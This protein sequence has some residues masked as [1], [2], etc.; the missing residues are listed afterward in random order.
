IVTTFLVLLLA[1]RFVVWAAQRGRSVSNPG[2]RL[3][4]GNLHRPGNATTSVMLSVGLGLTVLATIAM[5]ERNLT[6]QIEQQLP[7]KAPAFFFIDIQNDQ[8]EQFEKTL[9]DVPGVERVDRVPM[10]RGRV[11]SI[12]ETPVEELENVAQDVR[13]VIESERGLTYMAKPSEGTELAEGEWW[14]EDYRG[15]PLISFGEEQ[16]KGLGIGVGDT[17][18]VNVLGRDI[19]GKIANLRKI[20]FR[21]L[22]INF[23]IV[24]S[25]GMLDSAPHTHLATAYMTESA[26]ET[27][28]DAVGDG[29]PNIT[30]VRVKDAIEAASQLVGSIAGGIRVAAIFTLIAGV[31]VLAGGMLAS[32]QRRLYDAV[33]LKVLGATRRRVVGAFAIEYGLLATATA[34]VA[35]AVGSLA[36][37]GVIDGFMGASWMF[38]PGALAVVLVTCAAIVMSVGLVGTWRILSQKAAPL[39]RN[40]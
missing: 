21:S 9:K 40:E 29:F 28:F 34:L 3:A 24:F 5:I 14:P 15:E 7:S 38:Q 10:L 19:T 11:M 36:S 23:V 30:I 35:G 12:N 22:S 32:H 16:A 4:L 20:D 13:W 1:A 2:L 37:Y 27:A 6:Y 31:L 33:V 25:P 8:V 39:L 18:T 17:V 26:E